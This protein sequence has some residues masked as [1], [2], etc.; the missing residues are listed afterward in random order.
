VRRRTGGFASF[1]AV[2]PEEWTHGERPGTI[3]E[4]PLACE[5]THLAWTSQRGLRERTAPCDKPNGKLSLN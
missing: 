5:D 1:T 4:A 2:C 3:P